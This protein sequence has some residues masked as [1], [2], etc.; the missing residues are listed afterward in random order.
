MPVRGD[1][2]MIMRELLR[3][4]AP[5]PTTQAKQQ[6]GEPTLEELRSQICISQPDP[7]RPQRRPFTPRERSKMIFALS[8]AQSMA[9]RALM[10]LGRRDEYH[11]RQA[12]RTFHRADLDFPALDASVSRIRSALNRLNVFTNVECGTCDD[13]VCNGNPLAYTKD[14]LS[15]VV[16]CPFVFNVPVTQLAITFVHEAGHMAQIDV[17][18]MP[19]NEEYCTRDTVGVDPGNICPDLQSGDLTQN[20]DAWARF[21]YYLSVSS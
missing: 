21:I 5:A 14:D 13:A 17:N 12:A 19:G 1:Q 16:M 10:V 8:A 3:G 20:V 2:R 11:L 9:S 4:S 6:V 18:W 15:A 7:T